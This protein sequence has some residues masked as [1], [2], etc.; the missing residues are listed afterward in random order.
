VICVHNL[1]NFEVQPNVD[2]KQ[3]IRITTGVRKE[4]LLPVVGLSSLSGVCGSLS[5]ESSFNFM[6]KYR[7]RHMLIT[8]VDGV[9]R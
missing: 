9:S 2:A 8:H 4:A 7:R 3:R 5:G 6:H 1:R